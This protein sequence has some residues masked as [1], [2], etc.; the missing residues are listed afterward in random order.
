MYYVAYEEK[1]TKQKR[2]KVCGNKKEVFDY[3]KKIMP[4]QVPDSNELSDL[5]E[6]IGD[7]WTI[8]KL[9]SDTRK[10][11]ENHF[12]KKGTELEGSKEY[13]PEIVAS[14]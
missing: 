5:N 7:R 1:N 6:A 14:L 11:L 12:G 13:L 2:W 4:K 8:A 3:F 10:K 9:T